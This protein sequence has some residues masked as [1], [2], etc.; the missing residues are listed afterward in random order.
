MWMKLPKSWHWSIFYIYIFFISWLYRKKEYLFVCFRRGKVCGQ[1]RWSLWYGWAT[2][3]FAGCMLCWCMA[4]QLTYFCRMQVSMIGRTC[5]FS[6]CCVT[7][8]KRVVPEVKIY[9]YTKQSTHKIVS[10]SPPHDVILNIFLLWKLQCWLWTTCCFF[11]GFPLRDCLKEFLRKSISA[12]RYWQVVIDLG[13]Q[14]FEALKY[15]HQQGICHL[16]IK[17]ESHYS[18]P[19]RTFV[20][21]IPNVALVHLYTSKTFVFRMPNIGLACTVIRWKGICHLT[22]KCESHLNPYTNQASVTRISNVNH[23]IHT[24]TGHL[25]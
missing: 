22:T 11:T 13:N 19:N 3:A 16:D 18:F 1:R 7:R 23:I 17:R 15:M 9:L 8:R 14:G 25:S 21:R 24:S 12:V 6:Y 4:Q 10:G 2:Q 5:F 20:F